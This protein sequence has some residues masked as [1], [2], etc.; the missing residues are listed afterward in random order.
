MMTMMM[1]VIKQNP[2]SDDVPAVQLS[3]KPT[4]LTFLFDRN[5]T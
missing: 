3:E 4:S 2:D 5:L 1:M